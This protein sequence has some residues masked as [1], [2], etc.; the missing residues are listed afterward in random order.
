MH[1]LYS[2]LLHLPPL[3]FHC[4]G[5]CW[6]RTTAMPVRRSITIRLD[7]IHSRLDLIHTRLDL[8]HGWDRCNYYTWTQAG[9]HG[10]NGTGLQMAQLVSVRTKSCTARILYENFLIRIASHIRNEKTEP[11]GLP[12]WS[13]F[14][15]TNSRI[16]AKCNVIQ[17][18]IY[19]R[20]VSS[21]TVRNRLKGV[22]G[23]RG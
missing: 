8:I 9:L 10:V 2:T 21:M 4:V 17:D 22:R 1:V 20:G 13:F 3:R 7:L 6:D 5:G 11:T 18:L 12:S 14:M 15:G 19:Q 23:R 16:H